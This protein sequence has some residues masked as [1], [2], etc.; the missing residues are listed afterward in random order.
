MGDIKWGV[1][2]V[3]YGHRDGGSNYDCENIVARDVAHLLKKLT[4]EMARGYYVES[5]KRICD[6]D[7]VLCK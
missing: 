6:V 5:A 1:Y 2:E 7:K 4:K 3:T